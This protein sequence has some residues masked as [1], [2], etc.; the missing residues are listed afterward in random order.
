M[1][2]TTFRLI[3]AL[4]TFAVG[5]G[6]VAV[7]L[8]HHQL[9]RASPREIENTV[10]DCIIL[11]I[12]TRADGPVYPNGDILSFRLYQSGRI[13]YDT[14]PANPSEGRF[15]TSIPSR[16][17]SHL[18]S[19]E[20]EELTN[21]AGQTDL[22]YGPDNYPSFLH[23][24]RDFTIETTIVFNHLGKEKRVVIRNYA[25]DDPDAKHHYPASLI[26]LLQMASELRPPNSG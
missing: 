6:A 22:F 14:F 1:K 19:R 12:S 25:P 18:D 15:S 10:S 4:V 20:I 2:R 9:P 16:K 24:Q 17:E 5:V 8:F 7:W 23:E 26:K 3:V 13:E 11:E 21:L